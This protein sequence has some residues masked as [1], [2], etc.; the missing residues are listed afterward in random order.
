RADALFCEAFTALDEY[1][2]M[3]AAVDVPL[4]ANMTEFGKTPLFTVDALRDA[5]VS[6]V[7]Y[8]VTTWRLALGAVERGLRGLLAEGTQAAALP[9]MM[10]RGRLYEL[11][12]YDAYGRLDAAVADHGYREAAPTSSDEGAPT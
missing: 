7:L 2:A 12:D 4:L 9:D 3:R 5:G 1:R 6:M 11:V 10:T 8:P